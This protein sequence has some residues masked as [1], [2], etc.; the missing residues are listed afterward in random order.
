MEVV[1]HESTIGHSVGDGATRSDSAKDNNSVPL[2]TEKFSYSNG[3]GT[4]DATFRMLPQKT[5]IDMQFE[6]ITYTAVEGGLFSKKNKK[7]ILHQ[8]NGRFPPGQLIAIMGPSGAGK[9]TLLDVLSGYRIR[10]IGGTV[11]INGTAR[12]LKEFRKLSCYITQDDRLQPLLTV[13]E[14]MEIAADLKL[15]SDV[16]KR[17]KNEIIDEILNTL[18]L[19]KSK[20]TKAGG[21]SGGQKKRM[22]IA[23]ELISN[24][25]VMFLDEPTTGLDSSSC[26]SC[27]KLLKEL[28][29][30]GRSI[31]CTIHQPSASLFQLFDQVYVLAAGNCLYQGST[32]SLV[33]FLDTVGFACPKFHNPADY[34]IELACGEYGYDKIEEMIRA[35]NNGRSLTHFNEPEKLSYGKM[36]KALHFCVSAEEGNASDNGEEALVATSKYNQLKVLLRRGF[37]K[38]KRDQTLTYL[39]IG[40]NVMVGLMLGTLYIKAGIDGSKVLDNYN[41]LFSILMHHMMST[42]MLTIL[43]FPAEMSILIKEHFNR[44]Y[45]L[46]MYYTSVTLVDIPLSV[47]CCFIF[48]VI[49]YYMTSQ[50]PELVRFS[51]FFVTSLLVVFVA[52]SFGLMIGAYFNVVNGTFLGPTLSVP[53]MMF[54][55]FG[56]SLRDLPYYLYW[57]SYI[58]YLRFGL[59]GI[60]GAVYGLDRGEIACPEDMYCHYKYPKKFLQDV[61]VRADQFDNDVIALILFL[62]VLRISAY[63]ILRYKLMAVR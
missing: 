12:N 20:K 60:V 41:L 42:M 10:G 33:P 29:R 24:P 56:V 21:L 1:I 53:M 57:G 34:V 19:F 17:E 49:I 43:T 28:A 50:P 27:V 18:G 40:V 14:N 58:S 54:A 35:T 26:T 39:R 44:W 38:A 47:F 23:L 30:Q 55:G 62:F 7:E 16:S 4:A 9:S 61:A 51:M 45:S 5:P 31:I 25:L 32:D 15:S 3:N 2:K 52:Q 36:L 48:S 59:E 8:V 63:V 13:E 22:S 6:N 37:I 46:K 11:Y